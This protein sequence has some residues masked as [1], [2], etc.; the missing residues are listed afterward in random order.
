[1]KRVNEHVQH[2][3]TTAHTGVARVIA[4]G[5]VGYWFF[6]RGTIIHA[7]TLDLVGEEAALQMLTW[8]DVKWEACSR[9]WPSEQTIFLSWVELFQR[10]GE[11]QR[12]ELSAAVSPPVA[13]LSEP[14]PQRAAPVL[15][16]GLLRAEPPRREPPLISAAQLE[17][18]ADH[19]VDFVLIESDGR[20]R[21][22][23]GQAEPLTELASYAA[24]LCER[25]GSE[26]GIGPCHALEVPYR[27]KTLMV[28]SRGSHT[29]GL[30]IPRD[31]DLDRVRAKLR[32]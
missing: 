14:P 31:A 19:A 26:L 5:D 24:Q 16:S 18:L 2:A 25:I 29:L 27:T 23:R 20:S 1:M 11:Q 30:T 7:M 10:A 8:E 28:A 21:T 15:S 3:C 4:F 9:P 17:S 12:T 13:P 22:L 32:A 6:R